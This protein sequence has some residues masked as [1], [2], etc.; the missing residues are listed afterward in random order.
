[1][2]L[3]NWIKKTQ[4]DKN[5]KLI[6]LVRKMLQSCVCFGKRRSKRRS[7][8]FEDSSSCRSSEIERGGELLNNGKNGHAG[9]SGNSILKFL[10]SKGLQRNWRKAERG[11]SMTK[12]ERSKFFILF[13]F[14]SAIVISSEL[15]MLKKP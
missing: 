1:M 6:G 9:G 7:S 13:E 5:P 4:R 14:F 3:A 12:A 11:M 2:A 10:R 8:S 15:L